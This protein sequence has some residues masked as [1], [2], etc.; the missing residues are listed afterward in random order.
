MIN[1]YFIL[2]CIIYVRQLTIASD[3]F[4]GEKQVVPCGLYGFRCLNEKRAQICDDILEDDG[5]SYRPRIFVCAEG[6]VC[7][8][9][10]KE[11]C[12]PVEPSH[13]NS[14]CS[15]ANIRKKKSKSKKY[16][17]RDWSDF[18]E[19]ANDTTTTISKTTVDDDEDDEKP[20]TEGPKV[21]AWNGNPPITCAMYGFYP[22]S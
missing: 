17:K 2:F 6:L 20:N 3:A 4:E 18:L 7:D 9:N 1:F 22:G 19:D 12:S 8:E 11:F 21:D 14:N 15:K 16:Y 13:H 10:K 5:S